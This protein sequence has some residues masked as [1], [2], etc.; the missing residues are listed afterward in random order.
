MMAGFVAMAGGMLWYSQIPTHASFASDL[1][2]G[3]LLVGFALPFTW[4]PVSIAALAGVQPHEAGLASGL[5][6]TAQQ[7]GGAIGVAVASSVSLSHFNHEL[8]AGLKFPEAFTS[9]SQWAFWV[10]V[11]VAV[12]SLLA[13][14]ALIRRDDLAPIG[15]AVGVPA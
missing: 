2:P 5:I 10:M 11:G 9:G 3:Y 13:T 6:S 7:V 15:E 1:L 12:A 14:I 8:K 4:I